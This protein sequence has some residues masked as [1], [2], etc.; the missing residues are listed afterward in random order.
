[1]MREVG[2]ISKLGGK[3]KDEKLK[4]ITSKYLA[5]N[6]LL[7]QKLMLEI[8]KL[9]VNDEIDL[10]RICALDNYTRL[11]VKHIDLVDR[12]IL[13]GETIPHEEKMMSIF[14]DY[15]EWI[16]KGKFRPSVELGKKISITT[17]QFDLILY[18]KIMDNEQDRDIV[19]QIADNLL[20]KY[21]LIKSL[22]LDKGHWNAENK[23][24]LELVIPTV[25]LPKLGKRTVEERKLE[26][27]KQFKRL[28][29]K[30]S[31]IESNIN[32]L[33]HRG[34]DRCPDRGYFHFRS[35][36]AMSI[37]AYNLKK[38]GKK[39]LEDQLKESLK[40]AA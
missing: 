12:R 7:L 13:K 28:K 10:A 14:E 24:L 6:Q 20:N 3:N 22:S 23:A 33:A 19:I 1:M 11:L 37:C 38:I 27:S 2:R 15:T 17:D 4:T 35:Y 5:K 36:V 18:Y 21:K 39:I 32:E 25:I 40:N 26:E 8:V 31:A 29:N 34:L 16:V 30:H 9:P